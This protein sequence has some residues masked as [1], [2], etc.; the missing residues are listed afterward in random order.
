MKK[1]SGFSIHTLGCK[2]NF[3]ES[4][5]ISSQLIQSGFYLSDDPDLIIINSCAVTAAAVKKTRN[6][7]SKLHHQHPDAQIFVIGCYSELEPQTALQWK[8]VVQTFGTKDKIN[9][10]EYLKQSTIPEAPYFYST[11]SLTDRTRSFL[12]IQDGCDYHCS[13]C[14]VASARGESRSDSIEN[15]IQN[16]QTIANQGIK[17]VNLTGVNVGDFGRNQGTNLYN[18]LLKIEELQ[19]ID[20][21]RISSIE[22]NLLSKEIIDLI[23]Q[24]QHLMPH[25]HLPLQSGSDTILSEM[26]RRYNTKMFADKV[27]YIKEKMPDSCI[28]VDVITGF[29]GETD[30]LFNETLNFIEQLPISY[31]HVFTYSQRPGTPAAIAPYQVEATEKKE[32]TKQLLDLSKKKK[33][34]FYQSQLNKTRPV[35]FEEINH[36]NTTLGFTDNYVRVKTA[37][38]DDK[39]NQI[40]ETLIT[41]DMLVYDDPNS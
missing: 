29:P 2:L 41:K 30:L 19:L 18:L 10:I 39:V 20:R 13:Y 28:A 22:P 12:K 3:S 6:L 25:F 37:Y 21:V 26:K 27:H 40:I 7:T 9:L 35:L 16:I 32:R 33:K 17:E 23:G 34:Q 36:N 14:T 15:V 11:Y 38:S 1:K 5:Y 4:S 31:L 8:G 24:S